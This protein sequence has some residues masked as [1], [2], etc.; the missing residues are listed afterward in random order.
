MR[1]SARRPDSGPAVLGGGPLVIDRLGGWAVATADADWGFI[2][3]RGMIGG[4]GWAIQLLGN[5]RQIISTHWAD[6]FG[7]QP[8]YHLAK[9]GFM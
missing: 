7:S 6:S 8:I 4:C 5:V 9:L 2:G 1:L 3:G